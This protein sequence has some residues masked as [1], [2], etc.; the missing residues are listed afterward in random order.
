MNK[1]HSIG[2][3]LAVCGAC[4]FA[5]PN[6]VAF[7][8][9]AEPKSSVLLDGLDNPCGVAVQPGTGM[10][11]VSDSAAGRIVRV[12]AKTKKSEPVITGFPQDIYGKGPKFNIG[13][14]GLA[15]LDEN[16]LVVGGGGLVDGMEVVQ[17]YE[18]PP[19]GKSLTQDKTKYQLGPIGPGEQSPKGE[20]NFYAL[21]VGKE[22]I[23]VTCNGDDTKGW[24]AKIE[25]K[26]GVPTNM[27]PFIATKVATNVDAP[28]GITMDKEGRIIV[29]Q[30]GEINVPGDSLVTAYDAQ[31]GKMLANA[32]TGLN[33]IAG[34]AISP[35]SNK[36][37][38]VDYAWNTANGGLYRL[39]VEHAEKEIKVTAVKIMALDKPSALAFGP[40]GG[41]FVTTFGSAK[42][43]SK[44]KPGQLLMIT[45]D[46]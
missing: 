17:V 21:A 46:L 4:L 36:L 22:G 31:T 40:D 12:S 32:T 18:V 11:F 10:V 30:M 37:Y 42:E 29:G 9:A 16:T 24:V 41:L 39:D 26:D 19:A 14:L 35:K 28:V 44:T 45:G 5:A 13:P 43:G 3:A 6:S 1:K 27:A 8:S 20:G 2:L 25:L 7:L 38:A 34:L 23:Y 15:F 33:D